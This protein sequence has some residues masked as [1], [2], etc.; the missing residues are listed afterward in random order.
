MSG[1]PTAFDP[2]AP[3]WQLPLIRY[4][5]PDGHSW[6]SVRSAS[7]WRTCPRCHERFLADDVDAKPTKLR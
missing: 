6:T 2:D 5:C 3:A 4:S 7:T 1:D